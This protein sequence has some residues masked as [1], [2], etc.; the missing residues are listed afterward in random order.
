MAI[1]DKLTYLNTTKT[2]IREGLNSLGADLDTEDT[3]RSY[4]D[5]IDGIYEDY[6]KITGEGTDLSLDNTK[7]ASMKIDYKGQ[8]SQVQYTGQNLLPN[9]AITR[10]ANGI[11]FTKNSDG[12]ITMNGTCTGN[13]DLYFV[14]DYD[15][16]SDFGL[17]TGTYNLNGCTNG[18][19]QTYM[20]FAVLRRNG[21][22][23]Y[24]SSVNASGRVMIVETGDEFRIFIRV[25][26]GQVLN[27]ITIYPQINA[28][29]TALPYIPYVGGIPSPNPNYPQD[30]HVVSGDNT[31]DIC[32]KNL[33]DKDNA[34]YVN[35]WIDGTTMRL[36]T[37]NG[38]R[39]FYIPCKPNTT[40]T[41]SRSIITSS[42][43]TTTYDST[44]FPT[45]TSSN[46]DYTVGSVLKNDNGKTL[47]I[48]TGANAKY[49]VVHYGKIEDTNLNETLASIQLE[50]GSTATT[51]E[52]YI[53]NSY[54]ITLPSGIELCKI[55][56]YQDYIYKEDGSWYLHKEIGKVVLNGSESWTYSLQA[57]VSRLDTT[58]INAKK[59]STTNNPIL[60]T[61]FKSEFAL[62]NGNIFLSGAGDLIS[63]T[64]NDFSNANDFKNW[65]SSTNVTAYYAFANPTVTEITDTTLLEQ[66]EESKLSYI[67]Q[68]NISQENNDLPFNLDVKALRGE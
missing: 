4:A 7:Q 21:S 15:N 25:F 16:Y 60:S 59:G 41:I 2:K 67:S 40:Y 46:V 38:N 58:M 43:R 55:G 11:T 23:Y 14:G 18:S 29:N 54:H 56:T 64:D 19:E 5:A 50:K 27:N 57:N 31:I 13:V 22:L 36:N 9:N 51:Y 8:T 49:L 35:G 63:I 3:F 20:L 48:T 24:Y 61:H 45:A 65:L 52:P 37:I 33:F 10:T 44:P 53:E 32:G 12:S 26:N 6:P 47:T 28:G 34:N 1:S 68:T 62:A 66:L 39:M 17:T 30:I 42:F